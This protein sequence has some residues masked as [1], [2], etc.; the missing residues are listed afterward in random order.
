[1]LSSATCLLCGD[2][3]PQPRSL[4]SRATVPSD[5]ETPGI[6]EQSEKYKTL[7]VSCLKV[8][9]PPSYQYDLEDE[10]KGVR[11]QIR[12]T[13]QCLSIWTRSRCPAFLSRQT[14]F[15]NYRVRTA[16]RSCSHHTEHG[17][18]SYSNRSCHRSLPAADAFRPLRY[19]F[20]SERQTPPTSPL[21][22]FP[23][24]PHGSGRRV[25]KNSYKRKR[26]RPSHS[27]FSLENGPSN[28]HV[29]SPRAEPRNTKG[30]LQ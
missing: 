20:P 19:V 26:F 24:C 7:N 16:A 28:P 17:A 30:R 9:V 1:M 12:D 8:K 22:H 29:L 10:S 5:Q 4:I 21:L 23:L 25:L 13:Q 11:P 15:C 14:D 6:R 3:N 2:K 18:S 27:Q